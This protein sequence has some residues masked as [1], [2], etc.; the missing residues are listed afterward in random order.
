MSYELSYDVL[1]S[2][3]AHACRQ[4]NRLRIS[5][6][7]MNLA[8]SA[9]EL[10]LWEWDIVHDEIW[11]TENGRALYGIARTERISFDRFM[12]SLYAEDRE[13]VRQA[14]HKLLAGGGA[15]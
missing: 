15:I 8:M 13:P 4:V 12:N 3:L 6:Q 11:S 2:Q 7:R 9:A 14:T 5:E 1:R 10:A